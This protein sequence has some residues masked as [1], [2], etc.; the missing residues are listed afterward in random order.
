M[1]VDPNIRAGYP[2]DA[3]YDFDCASVGIGPF[4]GYVPNPKYPTPDGDS[5]R[6]CSTK[7]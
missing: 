5:G 3:N 4:A 2:E 6:G 1:S 7:T